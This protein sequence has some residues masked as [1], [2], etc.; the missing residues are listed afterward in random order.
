[1]QPSFSMRIYFLGA[2]NF[3][4]IYIYK[5]YFFVFQM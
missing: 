5:D 4:I 2:S 1:M 3:V